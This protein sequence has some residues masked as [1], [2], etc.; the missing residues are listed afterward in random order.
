MDESQPENQREIAK[1][2]PL[3]PAAEA[4]LDLSVL[5]AFRS[6]V[7]GRAFGEA[8]EAALVEIDMRLARLP[9]Q[10][11]T[12]DG[13]L[14]SRAAGE[15]GDVAEEIGLC[16]VGAIAQRLSALASG[17]D[18]PARAA[19]SRRL[20]RAGEASLMRVAEISVT[21]EDNAGGL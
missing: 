3:H 18:A 6:H 11:R 4:D 1:V 19:V 21:I 17:A 5:A 8:L 16:G 12:G 20:M 13:A 9:A 15:L 7:G 14:I 2:T 10:I